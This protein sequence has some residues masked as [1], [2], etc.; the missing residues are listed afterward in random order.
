MVWTW[1]AR[2]IAKLIRE[3]GVLGKIASLYVA[4]GHAVTLN[5]KVGEHRVDIVASKDNVKYAIKT[6]LTSNPVTPKEVEE[7]ANASSKFNAKPTLLI[8]GSAKIPEETLSK[9]KELGVKLKRVRKITLTP[10]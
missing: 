1:T 2:K 9:A 8:Y 7:I 5:V 6:H 4:S 10:H 3:N